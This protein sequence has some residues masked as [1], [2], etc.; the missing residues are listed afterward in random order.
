MRR[1][2]I[3]GS[4]GSGKSTL[5]RQLQTILGLPVFHLDRLYW[6][7]GWVPTERQE[8]RQIQQE[9]IGRPEWIIDGNYGSTVELRVEA[10]D[11]IIFLDLPRA[12]CLWRAFQRRITYRAADRPDMG[13]GCPE[14]VDWAFVTWIWNFPARDRPKLLNLLERYRHTKQVIHLRSPREANAFLATLR[15]E[16]QARS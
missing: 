3:I 5:A 7:P 11:T 9:L 8:W 16:K 1:I 13:E 6:K 14:K 2:A 4:S 10:A 15:K 12:L